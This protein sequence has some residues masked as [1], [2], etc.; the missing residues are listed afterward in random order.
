MQKFDQLSKYAVL[1][2]GYYYRGTG[3]LN[4]NGCGEYVTSIHHYQYVHLYLPD[5]IA[6]TESR[7]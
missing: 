1:C 3:T 2:I 7:Q 6:E 5:M 4:R